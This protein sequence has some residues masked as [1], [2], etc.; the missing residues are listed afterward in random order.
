MEK[1]NHICNHQQL[2][3][4][5]LARRER[6]IYIFTCQEEDNPT[7]TMNQQQLE[8]L[9]L[10]VDMPRRK[11]LIYISTCQKEDSHIINHQQ[12]E[13]LLLTVLIH[14]RRKRSMFISICLKEQ[15]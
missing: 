1:L 13:V 14:Q 6:L 12:L 15:N 9:W 7:D 11:S 4:L 8:V 2:Q 3:D 5:L 10:T